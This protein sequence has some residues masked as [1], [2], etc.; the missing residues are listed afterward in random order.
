MVEDTSEFSYTTIVETQKAYYESGATRTVSFRK[1]MLKKLKEAILENEDSIIDAVNKDLG[2]SL[3]E[4]ISTEVG[5]TLSEINHTVKNISKWDRKQSVRSNPL[6]L[7]NKST[8]INEPYGSTL[9]IGPW[10]YPFQLAI[11]PLVGAIAGGNCAVVK[12]SELAP[13]TAAVINTLLSATF[14]PAYIAVVEGA[15]PETN[16]LLEERF[17]LIFF[18]GS[19]Q[20]GR[21]IMEK[22][23]KHLTPVVLELGGKAQQ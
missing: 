15:V 21:I 19:T 12:P 18:T 9:I 1:E 3:F 22:A 23:A 7:L 10:N 2:K 20:V 16:A 6:N 14:D 4:C 17:D 11:A 5:F 8:I 13:H